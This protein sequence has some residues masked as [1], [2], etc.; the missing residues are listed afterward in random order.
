[1]SVVTSGSKVLLVGVIVGLA[2]GCSSS[3]GQPL[4]LPTAG[5]SGTTGDAGTADVAGVAGAAGASDTDGGGVDGAIVMISPTTGCGTDPGQAIGTRVMHQLQTMGIKDPSCA[6]SQCGAWSY[7][8]DYWLR[9]PTGYDETK[10]YPLVF[11]GPS[12]G[13]SGNYLYTIPDFDMNVVRVGLTPP[14]NSIGHATLPNQGCFDDHE[15]DDSVDWVFY[16]QL[17]DLLAGTVCFDRN[18]VFASGNNSGATL[19]NELG[20]KYAGDAAHPI[21]GIMASGGTLPTD[22]RYLPTCTNNPMAGLW[23][24]P[25][26]RSPYASPSDNKTAIARAMRVNHCTLGTGIDDATF[27]PFPISATDSST[28]EKIRGC[29]ELVPLVVCLLPG[30]QLSNDFVVDFA[31]PAFVDLLENPP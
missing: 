12:C 30:T 22:V 14:P 26:N 4:F 18:R 11:E 17:Y 19:A 7:V 1:V 16:E 23:I 3:P 29:P 20:C 28:C 25:I 13:S 8:R 10:A 31:W 2:A 21:R 27:D 9:L 6:D 24:Q 5:S 15:G